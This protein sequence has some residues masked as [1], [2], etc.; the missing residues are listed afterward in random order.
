MNKKFD[1]EDLNSIRSDGYFKDFSHI[2]I[3]NKVQYLFLPRSVSD[4]ALI[5]D[6]ASKNKL[7]LFPIGG[8]SNVLLGN[9][10]KRVL[11]MD[12][13]LPKTFD[14]NS[15]EV[16]VS[17]N[18]NLNSLINILKKNS[19]GGLEFLV[20]IPAHIGGLL[21]MNAGA[22]GKNISEYLKW[23]EVLNKKGEIEIIPKDKIEFSYRK[24]SIKDYILKAAFKFE[25][26]LEEEIDSQIKKFKKI[27][28][29]SQPINF[30]NL[31]CVFKN[32]KG[33]SAGKLIDECGLKG[34]K[35]GDAE[36]SEKHANFI[37]NK[38]NASFEDVTN[39]IKLIQRKVYAKTG[40]ELELEI[41]VLN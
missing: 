34:E 5:F 21:K 7:P 10:K 6:F 13:K 37:I 11:L 25:R 9:A 18:F 8:G 12:Y 40:I 33:E 4:L 26:K 38:G 39:L 41:T 1:I 14:V 27:R 20:T 3:G 36:I 2:K 32:P 23:I 17:A 24:S 15:D 29:D 19:L 30:P 28:K 22:F 31:G 35:I 16:V